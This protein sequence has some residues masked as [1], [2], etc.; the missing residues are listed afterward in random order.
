MT[1]PWSHWLERWLGLS[2]ETGE[3]AAW[4]VEW[5]WTWPAWLS[6][7]I[8][9]LIVAV[10]TATYARENR[11]ARP[12]FRA[13]LA[14]IRLALVAIAV[15]MLAQATLT[16]KRTGL[17]YVALIVD[18]SLSMT[19]AD[20][21]A[22]SVRAGIQPR[23]AAA[24]FDRLTRWNLARTLLLE[25][26][27]AFLRRLEEH[28]RL[29]WHWLS[30]SR[31]S[32]GSEAARASEAMAAEL[33]SREPSAASTRL[34][35]AIR[36]VLD[37]LRGNAPAAVVLV[38]D[39]INTEGPSLADAAADAR[40][41]GV[42]LYFV[43]L[44][45]DRPARDVKLS[46][47]LVDDTVFLG[48]VVFFE[49]KV[50]ASGFAGRTVEVTLRQEGQTTPVARTQL[51][52]GP[53]GQSQSARLAHRPRQEGVFRY[54]LEVEPLED[55][56]QI[57]DNRLEAVVRVRKER[58]RVLLV[59]AEPSYEY[60]YLRN[61]LAREPT[62][63]LATVLQDADPEHAGQDAAALGS[64]PVRRDDLFR[65]DVI[66][67]GDAD[68]ARLTPSMLRN[69]AEFVDQPGKGGAVACLAGPKFMPLAFR[70]T[71]LAKLLP[72]D[73]GS[74][75]LPSSDAAGENFVVRP[76][77]L[78]LSSPMLQLADDP[79]ENA[80]VWG[81]LPPLEWMLEIR[82]LKPG[83][84]VLAEHPS[85][86]MADG[87]PM[88]VLL[89][90]HVGAGKVLFQATD[91]TWRWRYRVGDAYFG[92]YWLQTIRY[93]AR[94]KLADGG[95]AVMLRADRREYRQQDPVRLRAR[96]RN[97]S[98]APAEDDGVTV[99]LESPAGG[100]RRV[101]LRRTTADRGGF[102]AVLENLPV[103]SYHAW[104][105]VP[106]PAGGAA[107][108]DFTVVAPPGEFARVETDTVEMQ[109][110]AEQSRGRYY[111]FSSAD[112][113][114]EELPEGRQ[115]PLEAFP[116][117]PLWNAWPVLAA[118]LALLIAEWVLRKLGGMA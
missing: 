51:K 106:Q 60:R 28:Y 19:I 81:S 24:G 95:Q 55:E 59:Q 110:A 9:V 76:T 64:F 6:L 46:D 97:E 17:P 15:F 62:V 50:S 1:D 80:A 3:G 66:V 89:L 26:N 78:G 45:S 118:F 107:A 27:A 37:E 53:D 5:S 47:L 34:G 12:A 103:G 38:T 68:P 102:E 96:F 16:L 42:P 94:S 75:R 71:P 100:T 99:V 4:G 41:R 108:T 105:A 104:I 11:R 49:A 92:R 74:V 33:R 72:M 36:A 77:E 69:L 87:R 116:P 111:T 67:L 93:L 7:L 20:R 88:P 25:N 57:D 79:A 48:D 73:L 32:T 114:L 21:Y 8:V 23:V 44:G 10:V 63:E 101:P 40:R 117:L 82:E 35:A 113:L 43:G 91:E 13:A 98:L 2:A 22:E 112:R 115:V 39:G 31:D 86:R 29:K 65:F 58:I 18:D 70:D 90:H 52:L 61:L 85:R 14:A 83:T 30:G 109:Q 56:S 84:R 54:T